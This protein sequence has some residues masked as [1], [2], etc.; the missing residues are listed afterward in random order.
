MISIG[1]VLR[2]QGIKGEIKVEPLSDPQFFCAIK[3]IFIDDIE[4]E[5]I[6]ASVR[7]EFVYL[8]LSKVDSRNRAE[9]LRD[10]IL[11][12][13]KKDLPTLKEGQFFY[14]DLVDCDLYD[15]NEKKLGS[16]VG[17][18]NY[19]ASD[20]LEIHFE[21]QF[22]STLCPYVEGLIVSADISNKKIIVSEKRLKELIG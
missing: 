9:D 3:K 22:G 6:S 13:P 20:L 16:I 8:K 21:G 17:V 14:A 5:I 15:E 1:K 7:G 12:V 4:Y 2:P 11:Y 18:E 19:G 10:K